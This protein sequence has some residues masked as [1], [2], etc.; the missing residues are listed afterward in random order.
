MRLLVD[1]HHHA[2]A[3]SLMLLFEDRFGVDV[4][5]PAGMEWFD[6]NIWQFEKWFH[7]DRVARQYLVGIWDGT[8]LIDGVYIKDDKRH[9]GRRLRGVTLD[10]ARQMNWDFVISTLPHNDEGFKGFA[11]QVGARFGVQVGNH[12]QN[13]RWD[14]SSFILLSATV[15]GMEDSVSW[16]KIFEWQGKPSIVYHQE[17]DA[18]KVFYYDIESAMNSKTVAS[19][20]NCFPE[21]PAYPWVR[22]LANR[23]SEEFDWK[24]YGAYGTTPVDELAAGDISYVPDIAAAMR[25]TRIPFH[26]KTASDGFGH[27]LHNWAST[28]R[29]IFWSKS[30]YTGK[31]A[32]PLW[33]DNVT[34]WD[35][36]SLP[37]DEM[38][39]IMRRLRDDDDFWAEKC[40]KVRK[41]FDEIVN[42]DHEAEQIASMLGIAISNNSK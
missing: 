25:R 20:V 28:G 35:I 29:P 2:L 17:F 19:F 39:A 41:R 34:A 14:L 22:G 37:E 8:E 9:P 15:P 7:G 38:I 36:G 33:E 4:Y 10:A 12:Q 16:G 24:I 42:F 3:E 27:V 30:N 21:S 6:S 23:N 18:N 5:F 1:F 11:D 32:S 40:I 31:L 26:A 13:S